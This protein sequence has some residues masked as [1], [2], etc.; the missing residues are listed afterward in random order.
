MATLLGSGD[1]QYEVDVD[2]GKLP[3]GWTYKEA[4]AVGVDAN[5]NVYVYSRGDHP[6]IVFDRHGNFQRSWGEDLF[7]RAHGIT[8]GRTNRSIA[9]TTA[10]TRFASA[11]T[12]ARCC[13]SLAC[14][15]RRRRCTAAS[16][17]TVAPT[18]PCARRTVTSM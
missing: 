7:A 1:F 13:C 8:M 6:M 14:R 16:R 9:P 18:S 15:A 12:T 17:S 2:W 10:I 5:D 3:D 11:R 4:A